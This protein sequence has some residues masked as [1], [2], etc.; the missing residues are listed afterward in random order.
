MSE[1]AWTWHWAALRLSVGVWPLRW[2]IGF[3]LPHRDWEA[4]GVFLGPLVIQRWIR[5]GRVSVTLPARRE[6]R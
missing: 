2:A 6:A 3:Q 5:R 4:F 1:F